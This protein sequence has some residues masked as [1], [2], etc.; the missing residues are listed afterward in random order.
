M[1]NSFSRERRIS[2]YSAISAASLFKR[3]GNFLAAERGQALQAQIE[4]GARLR[5]RQAAIAVGV[6]RVARIG[7]QRDQ[8]RHVLR[9]P[10]ARHQRLARGGGVR[11][12]ADEADDLVDIGDGDGE[13][14]LQ[15]RAVARLGE[16][17]LGAPRDDLFAEID[18]GAQ[19]VLQRQHFRPAAVQRDHV[20]ARSSIAARVALE[21]VQHHVGHRVALQLDDDAH[22]VAI[23][24]VAQIGDALDLLFA[25]EVGDALDQRRLVHLI[26][27]LGDDDRL[28]ILAHRLDLGLGAHDDRAAAGRYRRCGCRR[29]RGS[30]PPVGK[31]GPGTIS[32]SSAT[33]MSGRSIMRDRGVDDLAEI[34]RRDVGRHA[35]GDAAGAIDQQIGKARRQD[36]GSCSLPS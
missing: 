30:S 33:V 18:E 21:L 2:R 1:P 23:G 15:M 13:A 8:R 32:I 19:H 3:R 20:D 26:G 27:N 31:S 36:V 5:F 16:A 25:H 4:D 29:G 14:D 17:E 11:R 24:F 22:A 7:D 10:G 6:E 35:D 9:R 34:M 28:A 12:G